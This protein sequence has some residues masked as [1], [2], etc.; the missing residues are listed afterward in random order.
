MLVWWKSPPESRFLKP[1]N[2]QRNGR[3]DGEDDDK[4]IVSDIE[5]VLSLGGRD[6][7]KSMRYG[8]CVFVAVAVLLVVVVVVLILAMRVV[9]LMVVLGIV[10]LV[11][12]VRDSC[13]G[14][15]GVVGLLRIGALEVDCAGVVGN[16]VLGGVL[17]V[18]VAEGVKLMKGCVVR[19]AL[20]CVNGMGHILCRFSLKLVEMNGL[21][22][23]GFLFGMMIQADCF[24]LLER[25]FLGKMIGTDVLMDVVVEVVVVAAVDV[26]EAE[27]FVF[28]RRT[29]LVDVMGVRVVIEVVV[30]AVVLV[31]WRWCVVW[32]WVWK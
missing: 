9:L 21:S 20:W 14:V 3:K 28:L 2:I 5:G 7:C 6:I 15:L 12:V 18:E 19:M 32:E 13:I 25:A 11:M 8:I 10:V 22:V 24:V 23:G 17:M 16:L 4:G 1:C 27:F 31:L 26:V 29:C 30:G